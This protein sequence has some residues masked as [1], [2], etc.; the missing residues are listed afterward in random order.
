MPN[1]AQLLLLDKHGIDTLTKPAE[2]LDAVREAFVLHSR[3]AG[4]LFPVIRERLASGGVFG[5]KSGDAGTQALLGFKAAGFWPDNREIGCEP[6]QATILLIDP[7]TGRPLCVLDGNTITTIR[8]GAA[9]GLGLQRLA[10]PE[11]TRLCVFGTGIQAQI[12]TRFA[13]RLMPQLKTVRYISHSGQRRPLFEAALSEAAESI[14]CSLISAK[15]PDDAVAAS[16]I[17]V[18]A[19]PGGTPLFSANAVRPGTHLN[20]VGTDTVGKRELPEGLLSHVRLI[21]DDAT[22]ARTI[23]ELQ[24]AQD[25]PHLQLGDLLTHKFAFTRKPDDI[26]LF[27]M[28]GIALQDLTVARLL[29]NK[30]RA[31]GTGTFVPWPW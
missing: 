20:C 7:D 29:L 21:V 9:G 13:L 17:I 28:T 15:D 26:T 16:D 11:S 12:Q 4:R 18:T 25:T 30:A 5:I 1:N 27:D 31:T 8:T 23:G 22:Q 19:T 2:I 10:R 3:G 24:W 14:N 6:H